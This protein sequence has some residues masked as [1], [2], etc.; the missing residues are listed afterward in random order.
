MFLTS[1]SYISQAEGSG[2][3][4]NYDSKF[5]YMCM[6]MC[7]FAE[8]NVGK[9]IRTSHQYKSIDI[10]TMIRNQ[11]TLFVRLVRF[12]PSPYDPVG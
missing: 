11:C 7:V 12:T 8:E 6:G 3:S 5:L 10:Y 9:A 1:I 2:M 4:K